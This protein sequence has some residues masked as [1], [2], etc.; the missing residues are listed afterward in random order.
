MATQNETGHVRNLANFSR[1]IDLCTLFAQ[2]YNPINPNIQLSVLQQQY[3]AAQ[4]QFT[5]FNNAKTNYQTIVI[6]RQDAFSSAENLP[7][8]ILSV[9]KSNDTNPKLLKIVQNLTKKLRGQR[10]G[11]LTNDN[12][13]TTEDNNNKPT[14]TELN[15]TVSPFIDNNPASADNKTRSVSQ[16]SYDQRINHFNQ[17]LSVIQ[18]APTY[19]TNETDL[20]IS[21]LQNTVDNLFRLNQNISNA[22]YQLQDQRNLRNQNL[23]APNTGLIDLAFMVKEYIKSVFSTKSTEYK[24][25]AA[26][27]FVRR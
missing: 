10:I 20:Q 7:T 13:E 19:L 26:L 8:R 21:T 12:K 18:T 9:L 2:R 23:Y 15:L 25:V 16:R 14:D 22:E 4:Q 27:K 24:S 1:L 5:N 11:K 17:L 6:T 3:Q